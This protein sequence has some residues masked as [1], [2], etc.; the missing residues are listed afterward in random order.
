MWPYRT[1]T[2]SGSRGAESGVSSHA[3]CPLPRSSTFVPTVCHR[4]LPH[5]LRRCASRNNTISES[6]VLLGSGQPVSP[7][8]RDL[9]GLQASYSLHGESSP[10]LY[11]CCLDQPMESRR[12]SFQ[13]LGVRF[14]QPSGVIGSSNAAEV[15]ATHLA[16]AM[17]CDTREEMI[18]HFGG[19]GCRCFRPRFIN[20]HQQLLSVTVF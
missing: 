1:W 2:S 17:L 14:C 11:L 5:A 20:K 15:G 10:C 6:S 18:C 3:G 9:Q 19:K 8:R 13:S 16:Y 12:A 7:K 4:R